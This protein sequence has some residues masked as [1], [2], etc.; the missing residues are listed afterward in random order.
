MYKTK[1]FREKLVC[2]SVDKNHLIATDFYPYPFLS[3]NYFGISAFV[4]SSDYVTL[5]S[6]LL[7][8]LDAVLISV[9]HN[10]QRE[11]NI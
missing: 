8:E 10:S 2:T 1:S 6:S 3:I 9:I 5:L 7:M 11:A 4:D